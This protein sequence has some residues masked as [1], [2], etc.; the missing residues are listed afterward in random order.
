MC[1]F[2]LA[3]HLLKAFRERSQTTGGRLRADCLGRGGAVRPQGI[4]S[5]ACLCS[6]RPQVQKGPE[7]CANPLPKKPPCSALGAWNGARR[8]S[9]RSSGLRGCC[10]LHGD[11]PAL[12]ATLDTRPTGEGTQPKTSKK[13]PR[14]LKLRPRRERTFDNCFLL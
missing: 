8:H 12:S 1:V 3:Q 6:L 7:H 4:P 13:E 14:C 9:L 2:R 11:S 10:G 5:T